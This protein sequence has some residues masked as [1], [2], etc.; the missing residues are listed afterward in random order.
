[1]RATWV[2]E[3][4]CRSRPVGRL[5]GAR[6]GAPL[7]VGSGLRGLLLQTRAEYPSAS[8]D[9][10]ELLLLAAVLAGSQGGSS[11]GRRQHR[12]VSV[13]RNLRLGS[14]IP[15][16]PDE[17]SPLPHATWSHHNRFSQAMTET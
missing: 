10:G 11:P 6:G 2:R 16:T 1:E 3:G 17:R 8:C 4:E 13:T 14:H 7:D 15:P 9:V 5:C 12:V